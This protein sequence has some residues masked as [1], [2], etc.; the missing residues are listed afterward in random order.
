MSQRR[1]GLWLIGAVGGVSSTAVL[2]ISALGRKLTDTTSLVTATPMF[3]G[4]DLDDFGDFVIGGHDIRRSNYVEAV[5]DLHQRSNVFNE[6]LIQACQPDLEKWSANVRPGTVLGAGPTIGKL[7]DLPE[8]Q[9]VRTPREAIERVQADLKE[10]RDKNKLDQVVVANVSSTEPPRELDDRFSSVAKFRAALDSKDAT[11]PASAL[12]GWA[13]LDLGI[14]YINF[15]PSLG[16]SFPAALE[17]A[18][19]RKTSVCGKDGKTGETMMKSVLAPMF[20]YRN[21]KILSWVGHNIFGNRDGIVLDDPANKASK[22]QTKDQVVS[23]IVGYKPQTHVSIE[24]IESLD[25]WKTAW[26]HIHFQGF[27]N[28]KMILQFL[29][30]GCDSLLAAPLLIDIV[31]LTLLAQRRGETG[32]LKHLACFF[33]SPMGC[34]EHDFF[35]QM[36]MLAEYVATAKG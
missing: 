11:I 32:V 8:V 2:G 5:R 18:N 28:T 3:Q 4:V 12:Y 34:A 31:R 27:L 14:P 10:F 6:A 29:W 16:S 24:Y 30:Q 20:A 25:D 19:E 9:R 23:S 26:D 35:K 17:L 15:T 36:D 13:A 33:K 22:I 7:A 1:V 21:F